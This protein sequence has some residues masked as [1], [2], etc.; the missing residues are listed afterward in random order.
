MGREV[1]KLSFV[2]SLYFKI[3]HLKRAGKQKDFY[4]YGQKKPNSKPN[5]KYGHFPRPQLYT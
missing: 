3:L 5:Q 4:V 2:A 1:F